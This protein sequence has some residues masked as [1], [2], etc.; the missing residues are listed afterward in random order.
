MP[1]LEQE[2]TE[3][4][5]A[6]S[7]GEMNPQAIVEAGARMQQLIDQIDEKEMRLLEL[8]EKGE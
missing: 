8:M 2:K 4:E 1:A 7:S 6:M 5:A 3:L